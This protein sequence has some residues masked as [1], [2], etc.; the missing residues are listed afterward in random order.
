MKKQI[1]KTC[2][3]STYSRLLSFPSFPFQLVQKKI[4]P[5]SWLTS[6][7]GEKASQLCILQW[8]QTQCSPLHDHNL[9]RL[10]GV[11]QLLLPFP[12]YAEI[13][14]ILL[15]RIVFGRLWIGCL[16]LAVGYADH[17]RFPLSHKQTLMGSMSCGQILTTG[18]SKRCSGLQLVHLR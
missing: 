1:I 12:R 4:S 16:I 11:L 7:C 13:I 6:K 2:F 14:S 17:V 3:T 8:L 15:Y 9:S 5:K 18:A 10:S